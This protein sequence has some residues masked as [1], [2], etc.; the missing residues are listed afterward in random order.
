VVFD[1]FGKGV[2]KRREPAHGHTHGKV[3]A[4]Y[5][6]GGNVVLIGIAR[7]NVAHGSDNLGPA[8]TSGADRLGLIDFN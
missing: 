3:M 5:Q 8:I 6:T 1:L 7:H 2:R 4:F